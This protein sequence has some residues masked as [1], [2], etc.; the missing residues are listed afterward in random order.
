[1]AKPAAIQI[2]WWLTFL[3]LLLVGVDLAALI[4]SLVISRSVRVVA[5]EAEPLASETAAI[6]HEILAA[7]RDLFRYLSE[8][9]D[10]TSPALSHLSALDPHVTAARQAVGAEDSA[11]KELDAIRESAERYRK[12]LELMPRTVEGSRDWSRLQEYSATA[13]ELGNA[14]EQRATLLA[15]A[16]QADIRRRSVAADRIARA[17]MWATVGVFAVSAV[18]ILILRHWWQRFEDVILGM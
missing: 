2:R 4:G 9:A 7:Q 17:A 18:A 5:A 1:V 12:V 13:I 6:R 14:V 16:A 3:V 11:A 15:E 8:F 10:D